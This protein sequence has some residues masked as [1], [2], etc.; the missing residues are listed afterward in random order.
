M[1]ARLWAVSSG[2]EGPFQLEEVLVVARD[3]EQARRRAEERF[4]DAGQPVCRAKVRVADLGRAEDGL[5]AGPR[6]SG[7]TW[8]HGGANLGERCDP[9][10]DGQPAARS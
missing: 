2:W 9:A 1:R 10:P 8:T 3:A 4:A 7:E 6:R 5:I